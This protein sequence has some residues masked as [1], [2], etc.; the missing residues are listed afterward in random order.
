MDS[1]SRISAQALDQVPKELT[2]AGLTETWLDTCGPLHGADTAILTGDFIKDDGSNV[3]S[4]LGENAR[5]LVCCV[6]VLSRNVSSD[7]L[8]ELTK[9]LLLVRRWRVIIRLIKVVEDNV[10]MFDDCISLQ[11]IL[12]L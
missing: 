12:A 3:G 8:E 9:I 1:A 2:V 6:L 10:G 11:K 5:A 7:R 4:S